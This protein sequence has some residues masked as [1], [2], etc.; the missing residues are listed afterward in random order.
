MSTPLLRVENLRTWIDTDAAPVRA[1]DGVDFEIARG[2]TFA[3]LGESGC[4]K[5]MTAL[6]IM[7]LLPEAGRIISGSVWLGDLD[8]L[9]LPEAEMRG[10]RGGRVAMIFQEPGLSLNPVLTV[11]N[12][13]SEAVRRHTSLKGD[14]VRR[15]CIELLAQVGMPDPE[16]RL[17]EYPFQLSGG[18]KQ[19]VMIAMAL[20]GEPDLLIAD[21][22]TTALDVTIQAQVLDLLKRLQAETGMAILL[23]THDLGV[24]AQMAHTVAVMYAGQ[25][26]E[27]ARSGDFFSNPKHPYSR[28]LFASIPSE[29]SRHQPLAV[30]PGTVPALDQEFVGCRF[31]DRCDYAWDRC[32]RQAPAWIA[33]GERQGTRCHLYQ[34][35][36]IRGQESERVEKA[37]CGA[38]I[39]ALEASAA[40]PGLQTMNPLLQVSDLKVYFPIY[41]GVLKRVVGYV[42]AVDG[43]SLELPPG[44]TLAVVGESGSGKTTIGKAILQLVRPTAGRVRFGDSELTALSR[45][46]LRPLRRAFQIVFQDPYASLNPRMRV[47]DIIEEGM[48]ALGV[49]GSRE[50]RERRVV[51]LLERVGLPKEA[52]LRYPHEF[53][54]GQRQ[55][56]AIARALAV[57]P[58]LIVCD[59]PTSALDVSVQAQILNL[60]RE[61]QETLG[62]A[63]LFI[64]HNMGVVAHLAHAVA[65]VYL[66]RIVEQG[67]VDEVLKAPQHP[68]TQALLSAVPTI[69]PAK[70]R[71]VI[72]LQG[73]LPS[74]VNPPAGCH[75]HP[76]CPKAMDI[77][78]QVYPAETRL[79]ATRSV[80]CHLYAG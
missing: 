42:K 62:L 10:V 52:R 54:G 6:S 65:V 14:A 40:N 72:R 1:V 68:Y 21:E 25:I 58:K 75:F 28:K 18:M 55:R 53:S 39:G 48:R 13:L 26:V 34:D 41:K 66:G 23:V 64:T 71:E 12:Q 17:G 77:C 29:H 30:I 45:R 73:D 46:R 74:P 59:E 63:Y 36:G 24:V 80:H 76:R 50:E 16:R 31:A 8:L 56:I 4:G 2:E 5:S 22:P 79:S 27:T 60:L 49:G 70:Q 57:D 7:R 51:E 38:P 61:L 35:S 3:L 67:S 33:T 32:R 37:T 78:R 20:A 47:A 15:R 44:R 11:G 9:A 43:V 19:R 69:D